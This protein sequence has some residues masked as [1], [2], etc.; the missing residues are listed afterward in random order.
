MTLGLGTIQFGILLAAV[1]TSIARRRRS[2]VPVWPIAAASFAA[3][4]IPLAGIPLGGYLQGI[5]SELSVTTLLLI[6]LGLVARTGGH[7]LVGR[8]E[9]FGVLTLVLAGAAILYPMSLGLTLYDPYRLG[10]RSQWFLLALAF[11]ALGAWLSRR[12]LLLAV[13]CA[14]V[15]A[16]SFGLGESQ[17]LWDYLLDPFVAVF[18]L[19][20]IARD[21]RSSARSPNLGKSALQPG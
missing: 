3:A 13:L 21:L 5:A 6:S 8:R 7:D 10:F 1:A 2:K 11:L 19:V 4:L 16:F 9:L 18:A 14:S 12:R 15:V 17:N 20:W